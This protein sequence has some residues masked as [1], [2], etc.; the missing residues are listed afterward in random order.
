MGDNMVGKPLSADPVVVGHD[1]DVGDRRGASPPSQ[2]NAVQQL[3]D[4]LPERSPPHDGGQ[5]HE[6]DPTLLAPVLAEFF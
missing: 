2:L 5:T 3:A 1:P 6:V 4:V